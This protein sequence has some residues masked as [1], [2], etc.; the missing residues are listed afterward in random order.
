M[1]QNELGIGD[2]LGRGFL[3]FSQNLCA[4]IGTEALDWMGLAR[5]LRECLRR[6]RRPNH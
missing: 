5:E 6:I 1:D 2:G 4:R 3:H